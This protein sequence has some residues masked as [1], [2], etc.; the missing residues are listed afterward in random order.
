MSESQKPVLY[1]E[2]LDEYP[3][4]TVIAANLVMLAWI[5]IGTVCCYFFNKVAAW[6]YLG[7]ALLLVYVVLRRLVCVNC[8]YYGK[9]CSAGWGKLSAL[10]FK[11]GRVEDFNDGMGTMLAPAIYGLLTLVPLVLGTIAAIQHFSAIKPV[12]LAALLLL[13][14]YSGAIS[15]KRA[16]SRCRMRG[17][18]K[19]CAAPAP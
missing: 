3:V 2:G 14:I 1:D 16:C 6:V 5:A 15:R 13:G 17:Y 19:G 7:V 8:C 18:C 11:Q 9:R 4:G 12:F 10:M